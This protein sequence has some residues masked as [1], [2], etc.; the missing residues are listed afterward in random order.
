LV[1]AL[2]WWVACFIGAVALLLA[3]T[4]LMAELGRSRVVGPGAA[5]S[6][7]VVVFWAVLAALRVIP[8]AVPD[9]SRFSSL[10]SVCVALLVRLFLLVVVVRGGGCGG[11]AR[12]IF[13]VSS[14]RFWSCRAP[15]AAAA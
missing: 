14:T 10:H 11:A 12:P 9:S 1:V 3:S 6:P 4:V 13:L 7:V 5:C 8:G 15:A 2:D